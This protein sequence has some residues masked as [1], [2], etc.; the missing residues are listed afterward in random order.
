MPPFFIWRKSKMKYLFITIA[1][2]LISCGAEKNNK[3][4]EETK[5]ETKE[6]SS[7]MFKIKPD[8][9]SP[10]DEKDNIDSPAFYQTQEGENWIIATAKSTDKLFVYNAENGEVIKT[11]SGEGTELGKM[12]RPNGIWVHND[13]CLVV[14][15]NN[16]RVQ[17][18]KLPEFEPLGFI[19][20]DKLMKPYG[21]TVFEKDNKHHIYITDNYE[22][23]EDVIPADSL[24]D[25]RVL[26][27]SF[28]IE[29]G[30]LMDVNFEKYIG[31]TTG[32][33]VLKVVESIYADP[34]NDNLLICEELEGEGKTCIKLYDLEGNFK[35][36]IGLG[37]FK[38]QA[39][40]LALVE[41]SD[42]GY[43]ISTD[44]SYDANIFHFLDRNTFELK[45]SFQSDGL[46]NTDGIWLT[47][48]SF[49]EFSKGQFIAVN[50]DGGVGAWDLEKIMT[51]LNL[52]CD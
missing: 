31:E 4:A 1:I 21:L 51:K 12:D 19:G 27:Y 22:Y 36:N 25:K 33:G 37:L 45:A 24:L 15:R 52:Q 14:E 44:Q 28:N 17:V 26:H 49:G 48:K 8:V 41:C 32:D 30:K 11:V 7:E 40:G 38:S 3:K 50:N 47:Q 5:V 20:E 16:H 18:F 35:E 6:E 34:K 46:S 13:L 39:E 10:W 2:F 29:D 9:K 43:W 42:G 23:E